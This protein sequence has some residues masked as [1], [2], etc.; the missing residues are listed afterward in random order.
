M[1]LDPVGK[2]KGNGARGV[3]VGRD[4]HDLVADHLHDSSVSGGDELG[5]VLLEIADDR[6]ELA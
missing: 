5:C 4:Q 1:T 6:T 3:G 2:V